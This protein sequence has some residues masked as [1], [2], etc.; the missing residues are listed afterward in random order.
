MIGHCKSIRPSAELSLNE[1]RKLLTFE[2]MPDDL[3]VGRSEYVNGKNQ[4]LFRQ[5]A[6]IVPKVLLIVDKIV[7]PP[8][9]GT[10]GS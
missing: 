3:P 9:R 5:G 10:F 7:N 2:A 6:T 1:A 8:T 4:P